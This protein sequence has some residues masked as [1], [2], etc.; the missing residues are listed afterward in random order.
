MPIHEL[1]RTSMFVQRPGMG[2]L[3]PAVSDERVIVEW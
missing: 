1:A 2:N 3:L